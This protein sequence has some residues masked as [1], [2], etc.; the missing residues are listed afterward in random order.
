MNNKNFTEYSINGKFKYLDK[1]EYLKNYKRVK[2]V[3]IH[4]INFNVTI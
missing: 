4:K 1:I 3:D 2:I